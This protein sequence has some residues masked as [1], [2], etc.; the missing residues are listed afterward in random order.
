MHGSYCT[1]ISQCTVRIT[2]VY[3]NA[4]FVLHKYITM[5]GSYYTSISQSTVQKTQNFIKGWGFL[6]RLKEQIIV[7]SSLINIY[8]SRNID[9]P[10][11]DGSEEDMKPETGSYTYL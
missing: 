8:R 10:H 9:I 2:Q 4:R 5:H 7:N 11:V 1:G 3:H 6:D